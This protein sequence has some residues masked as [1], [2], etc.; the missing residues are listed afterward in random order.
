MESGWEPDAGAPTVNCPRCR[1]SVSGGANFC[2]YCGYR[3]RTPSAPVP[4]PFSPPARQTALD[5]VRGIGTY[6]T[7]LLTIL[8]TINVIIA[9][10]SLWLVLPET[11]ESK[12]YLFIVV[13]WIVNLVELGGVSFALYY[14]FV[15]IVVALSFIWMLWKS[16]KTFIQELMVVDLPSGHSPIYRTGTLFFALL[17]F[18][19]FYYLLL[20]SLGI[21]PTTPDYSTGELWKILYSLTNASVWEEIITRVAFIGVPLLS[22]DA[23]KHRKMHWKSYFL[24]GG[25]EVGRKEAMLLV[26]SSTMFAAAHLSNWDIFKF[27]PTFIAGLALGYL[28]IRFGLYASIMLHFAFDYLSVPLEISNSLIVAVLI[29]LVMLVWIAVGT[30]YFY[31]Y[32]IRVVE[33]ITG[34]EMWPP[35]FLRPK[36]LYTYAVSATGGHGMVPDAISGITAPSYTPGFGF[37]CRFCGYTEARYMDGALY[38]LNCGRRN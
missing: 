29:G 2:P 5:V 20:G 16:R 22:Y 28:F 21:N 9:L 3:L 31:Y 34:R 17:S 4:P 24:G 10:W 18:N 30:A 27:P 8:L 38:C 14:L 12:I 6:A 37:V 36:P 11:A 7:L 33:Y 13:P 15:V 26:F 23:L 1:M 35:R 32:T 19:F 25:M